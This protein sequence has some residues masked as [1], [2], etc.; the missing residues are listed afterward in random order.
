MPQLDSLT[1]F[2]QYI[3]LLISYVAVYVFAINVIIPKIV[4]AQKIRQK[5]NSIALA[6]QKLEQVSLDDN[7]WQTVDG[8]RSSKW[9]GSAKLG[10]KWPVGARALQ[11]YQTLEFKKRLCFLFLRPFDS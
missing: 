4:S 3:Y 1:Y 10:A 11:M 9:Q 8:L 7:Q 2:S 5:L 6:T